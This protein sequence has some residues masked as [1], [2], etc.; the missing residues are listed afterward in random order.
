MF[1]KTLIFSVIALALSAEISCAEIQK[2]FFEFMLPNGMNVFVFEDFSTPLVHAEFS[3]KAG[4]EI[5]N[6]TD[7][8]F[9]LL[10]ANLFA[11]GFSSQE[12]SEFQFESECKAN[13]EH[14]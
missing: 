12:T 9:F 4:Y 5:R 2:N 7:A 1:F 6:E 11:E 8:P 13:G 10:C 14:F 3:A